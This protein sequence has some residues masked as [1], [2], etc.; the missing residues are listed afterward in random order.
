MN[1]GELP[2]RGGCVETPDRASLQFILSGIRSIGEKIFLQA[3]TGFGLAQ[4]PCFFWPYK[5]R[6]PAG[7]DLISPKYM[8]NAVKG[9]HNIISIIETIWLT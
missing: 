4:P 2:C 7:F 3:E 1:E 5:R 9:W 6:S 8:L